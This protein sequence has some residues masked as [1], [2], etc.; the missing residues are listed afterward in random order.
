[1]KF[2][3]KTNLLTTKGPIKLDHY[4]SPRRKMYGHQSLSFDL[5]TSYVVGTD[6][7]LNFFL[8]FGNFVQPLPL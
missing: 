6:S 2:S 1:M 5:C 7:G 3:G 4:L 8:E